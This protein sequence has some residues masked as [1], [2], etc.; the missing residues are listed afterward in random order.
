MGDD[1]VGLIDPEVLGCDDLLEGIDGPLLD[2]QALLDD[3]SPI[4]EVRLGLKGQPARRL[5]VS[6]EVLS[7]Q[8]P[9]FLDD[10]RGHLIVEELVQQ[11]EGLFVIPRNIVPIRTS[12]NL[13]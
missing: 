8:D 4:A 5:L 6:P 9:V 11:I 10:L 3:R 13:T 2:P 7:I 1:P 12:W